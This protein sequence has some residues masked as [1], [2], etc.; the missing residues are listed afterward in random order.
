M[1]TRPSVVDAPKREAMRI[2]GDKVHS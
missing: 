1:S 2:A